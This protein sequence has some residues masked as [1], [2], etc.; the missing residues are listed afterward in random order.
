MSGF[1]KNGPG[2]Q[3]SSAREAVDFVYNLALS[4]LTLSLTNR[5]LATISL[6]GFYL[7][8]FLEKKMNERDIYNSLQIY[9]LGLCVNKYPRHVRR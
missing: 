3:L 2:Q 7:D 6:L 4:G 5:S 8:I 9:S 1:E